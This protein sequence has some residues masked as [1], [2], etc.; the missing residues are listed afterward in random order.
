[1]K[2]PV[3][4]ALLRE[5]RR[6]NDMTVRAAAKAAGISSATLWRVE[7]GRAPDVA[8]ALAVCRWLGVTMEYAFTGK[9]ADGV[10]CSRCIRTDVV[11][12]GIRADLA[13]LDQ[14][15]DTGGK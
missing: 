2:Y 7:S 10:A 4:V 3:L 14:P 9:A 13:A 11:L 12:A 8:T 1:M 5:R 6:L 15:R